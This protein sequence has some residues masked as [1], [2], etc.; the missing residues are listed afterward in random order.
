MIKNMPWSQTVAAAKSLQSCP[1]LCS[2]R[3]SSPPGSP[4][5][6]ILQAE[7]LEWVAI[8]FSANAH[9]CKCMRFSPRFPEM[10]V[11]WLPVWWSLTCGDGVWS[12]L[13]SGAGPQGT[14][15]LT[16]PCQPRWR[17]LLVPLRVP[18]WRGPCD[19][20][21][22]PHGCPRAGPLAT[23]LALT[24]ADGRVT[25]GAWDWECGDLGGCRAGLGCST[26]ALLFLE[27]PSLCWVVSP[28]PPH[29]TPPPDPCHSHSSNKPQPVRTVQPPPGRD[30]QPQPSISKCFS[31]LDPASGRN[32]DSEQRF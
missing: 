20:R 7:T 5:P 16:P 11:H 4:V 24:H 2:P 21:A 15:G 3:D 26:L 12:A 18:L 19:S 23:P 10:V 22:D 1:T 9:V 30:S 32:H 25:D 14:A 6:G 17:F 27:T 28:P 13:T 8:A 29:T 31:F